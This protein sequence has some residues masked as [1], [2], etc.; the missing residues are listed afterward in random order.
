MRALDDCA[1][2]LGGYCE[3]CAEMLKLGTHMISKK[4][5]KVENVNQD[6]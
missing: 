6:K 5:I 4:T 3:R 1:Y 2:L